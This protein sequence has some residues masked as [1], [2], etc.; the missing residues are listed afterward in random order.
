MIT[1]DPNEI[2]ILRQGG[3]ILATVLNMVASKVKPGVS[4]AE[5]DE[6]AETEIIKMGG[7]PS[8][9]N[10]RSQVGDPAFPASLCV[11][12]NN[13]VVHGVPGK[14]KILQ[15]GDIVGLDLGVI[16]QGLYT[17]SA[18]TVPVGNVSEKKLK[19]IE[20]AERSLEA[21]L[22]EVKPGKFT[23]DIGFAIESTTKKYNFQVVRELVG[24][25]VGKA[26][27]EE[28]EVPCFGKKGTGTK[29]V[30]GMV[31][32]IEPM[33]NENG[34]KINFAP[35]NWT[36]VT[37]DGGWSAHRE[38]TILVTEDGFEILT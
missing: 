30:Q 23:G 19:L 7:K 34:W 28:P 25:G 15:D 8:F 36:I 12:R 6:L 14:D 20:A 22:S 9:K 21:G 5:L 37:E 4:A 24:H 17:D 35:D 11:S 18:I 31:L 38:H 27:H 10:Y 32:A 2:K 33:V 16:Y 29:L 1:K 3:K 13:E 26:V